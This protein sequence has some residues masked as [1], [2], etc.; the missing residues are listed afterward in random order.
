MRWSSGLAL[1]GLLL[2]VEPLGA[3]EL[4]QDFDSG[5]LNVAASNVVGN[6]V[7][8]VGRQT[9]VGY[10]KYRWVYF[11]AS[12][13]ASLQPQFRI[14]SSLFD[15]KLSNPVDHSDPVGLHRYLYSYDQNNWQYFDNCSD[16][17]TT[18]RFSNN[19]PFTQNEVYVAYSVP[20]P[21]SRT[22]QH[23][24]TVIQSPFVQPTTS[25]NGGFV[26]GQTAGGTDDLGRTISPNNI[27]G[28]KITDTS[29][30]GEKTKILLAGGNHPCETPGNFALEGMI[31]FLLGDSL[32][33]ERLRGLADFYVYP[34]VNPDGRI[35]G[36][37][38]SSVE[39]PDK[40]YNRCWDDPTGMTDMTAARN[41]MFL[42]TGRDI[43]YLFD[44]HSMFGDWTRPPYY[45]TRSN[46]AN[47][48]FCQALAELEPGIAPSITSGRVG[49]L[50][51]RGIVDM[52]AEHS[53][54]PEFG[55]HY[56]VL[57]DELGEMGTNYAR[58]LYRAL[59]PRSMLVPGDATDDGVVDAADAAILAANWSES[60]ASWWM[61]DFND[62]GRVNAADAS[63][64]AA[65]WGDHREIS[66]VPEPAVA[67]HLI[68]AL[69]LVVHFRRAGRRRRLS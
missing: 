24:A 57:E 23:M 17:G 13:V 12:D 33:A 5:S 54:T 67:F 19:T 27:Y 34:Q 51:V 62:D 7:Y 47:S 48:A 68:V 39:C 18:Y 59:V 25:G 22:E 28:F 31:D 66:A 36:Y 49:M 50:R 8:L 10:S 6:T 58:A 20:Y 56:G 38:R 29:V 44:F 16:D 63:I 37:Y 61:G 65:N 32:E 42:D 41:A 2:L 60:D 30:S 40:D 52:G 64:L 14:S 1:L 3:I 53:F 9:W 45:E 69:G 4:S 35:A 55:C 21:L 15:G 43:D 11:K 46:S 26:V